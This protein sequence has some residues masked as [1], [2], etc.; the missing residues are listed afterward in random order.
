MDMRFHFN[1]FNIN[2][3]DVE[4]SVAFYREALGLEPVGVIDHPDL[5]YKIMYLS[6]PGEAFRLE[7]TWLADHKGPYELGENESHL[8][9]A[10]ETPEDFETAHAR[11]QAMGCICFENPAMGIY[12]IH[13]PDDYWVEIIPPRLDGRR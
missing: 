10:V 12:F 5:G 7:L 3:A 9:F 6:A 1:H 2:V 11:H 13:D 4:R 8:A